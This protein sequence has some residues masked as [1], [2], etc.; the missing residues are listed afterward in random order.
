MV[1]LHLQ[2]P[3]I[4]FCRNENTLLEYKSPAGVLSTTTTFVKNEV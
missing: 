2:Q 3:Y 1:L 4:S